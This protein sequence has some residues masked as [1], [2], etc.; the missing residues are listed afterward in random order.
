M[1][2]TAYDIVTLSGSGTKTLGAA[3]IIDAT[4]TLTLNSGVT[5]AMSTFLLTLNGNFVNNN[6][7][8]ATSGSGGVTITGAATTQSID[9]FTTTGAVSMTKTGGTATFMGNVNGAGLTI[10]GAGGGV[11][12]LGVV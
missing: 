5:F 1:K 8:N 6:S 7:G 9:G 10:N 4:G 12:N 3:T 2:G 11:L